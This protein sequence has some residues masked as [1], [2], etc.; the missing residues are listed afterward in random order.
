MNGFFFFGVIIFQC[1]KKYSYCD[2]IEI[3]DK[4]EKLKL[5]VNHT[6]HVSTPNNTLKQNVF[7][8]CT[9]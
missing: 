9:I 3:L 4:E 7:F 6:V 5:F 1:T 2:Q 8:A